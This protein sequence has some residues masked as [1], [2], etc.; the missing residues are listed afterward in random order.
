MSHTNLFSTPSKATEQPSPI[1]DL[2]AQFLLY[3]FTVY[4]F[5]L[6]HELYAPPTESLAL[7]VQSL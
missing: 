3:Y 7:Y 1:S 6:V 5:D 4:V 2:V